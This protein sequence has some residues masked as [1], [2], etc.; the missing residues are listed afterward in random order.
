MTVSVRSGLASGFCL[1]ALLMLA[2]CGTVSPKAG[3]A[4]MEAAVI[5]W[6]RKKV[7]RGAAVMRNLW[8]TSTDSQDRPMI[9]RWCAS[10]FCKMRGGWL[11]WFY[12][13]GKSTKTGGRV[14]GN[15]GKRISF[16]GTSSLNC[17]K[18][19][20]QLYT[21]PWSSE[22]SSAIWELKQ[23]RDWFLTPLLFDHCVGSLAMTKKRVQTC[24][25]RAILHSC[26]VLTCSRREKN[27][28]WR[29]TSWER[30]RHRRRRRSP[31]TRLSD[32]YF[33][34]PRC[35]R[36]FLSQSYNIITL[37]WRSILK[38]TWTEATH[39]EPPS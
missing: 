24:I 18:V 31:E 5:L 22:C 15:K 6:W 8:S 10:S 16:I 11:I 9:C 29:L 28:C 39:L 7:R 19:T 2:R 26:T 4:A 30:K 13:C 3:K 27:S 25:V 33:A 38:P 35:C 36:A 14:I 1:R 32:R 12:A 20:W 37:H 21:Y 34:Q 23:K 17:I